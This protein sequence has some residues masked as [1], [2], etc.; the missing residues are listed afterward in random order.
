LR[1][2]QPRGARPDAQPTRGAGRSLSHPGMQNHIELCGSTALV[3][4]RPIPLTAH[5]AKLF[6]AALA[7]P[8]VDEYPA[9]AV[10]R[11][12]NGV[13]ALVTATHTPCQRLGG[14]RFAAIA[15]IS[16]AR[17]YVLIPVALPI[18]SPGTWAL[19]EYVHLRRSKTGFLLRTGVQGFGREIRHPIEAS[20]GHGSRSQANSGCRST[21]RPRR[22]RAGDLGSFRQRLK[23]HHPAAL[24]L[25]YPA[26]LHQQ[27]DVAQHL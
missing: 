9:L 17:R 21:S 11:C 1:L 16:T 25:P 10:V 14:V 15:Q 27:V 19:P 13:E 5:L 8:E 7:G 24:H 18:A 22:S 2:R 12:P 20:R 4:V 26:F 6:A 3:V 23:E